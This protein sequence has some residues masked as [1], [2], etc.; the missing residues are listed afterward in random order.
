MPDIVISNLADV[1]KASYEKVAQHH[2][3]LLSLNSVL[4]KPAGGIHTICKSGK[5]CI[6][7]NI[8]FTKVAT[9]EKSTAQ[10][11]KHDTAMK[12]SSALDAAL[13]RGLIAEVAFWL[14]EHFCSALNDFHKFFDTIDISVL[15]RE[16]CFVDYPPV[17]LC[18]ALQ[19]HLAPRVIQVC[20][21]SSHQ[22]VI[23]GSILAGCKQSIPMTRTLLYNLMCKLSKKHPNAPPQ[24]FVDD[25][26]MSA[27]N[28][29][30]STVLNR[31]APCILDFAKGVKELELSLSSKAMLVASHPKLAK[32]LQHELANHDIEFKIPKPKEGARDLGIL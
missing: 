11:C 22:I 3:S 1:D 2:Q 10:S 23:T 6:I 16:A 8:V 12:G 15:L 27:R 13:H 18:L 30:W 28:P 7:F 17:E 19:Q 31:L 25:T 24:V 5:L 20:S 14:H 29:R 21:F 9:W 26:S 4:R 32:M